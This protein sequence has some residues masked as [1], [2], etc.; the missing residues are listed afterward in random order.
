MFLLEPCG[1]KAHVQVCGTTPCRL[2]GADAI[3][4]VCQKRIHHDPL[5]VSADGGSGI[6]NLLVRF[7]ALLPN[8]VIDMMVGE[9][10]L[11]GGSVLDFSN[12]EHIT[13][14]SLAGG[15]SLFGG[16]G[17]D[18][19]TIGTTDTGSWVIFTQGPPPGDT[20]DGRGGNDDLTG[21][22]LADTILGGAG[23]DIVKGYDRRHRA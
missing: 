23:D 3:F 22:D 11:R 13:A 7:S 4:E 9:A 2:R 15:T 21:G 18:S 17:N 12:F 16:D 6:D 20:L 10:A 8:T 19:L 5:H 14:N 1:K